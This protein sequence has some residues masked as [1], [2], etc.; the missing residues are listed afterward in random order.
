MKISSQST[1]H[2]FPQRSFLILVQPLCTHDLAATEQAPSKPQWSGPVFLGEVGLAPRRHLTV[3]WASPTKSM[4]E[5]G[6]R[7]Q[8]STPLH[9]TWWRSGSGQARAMEGEELGQ[10]GSSSGRNSGLLY[11]ASLAQN[12][13]AQASGTVTFSKTSLPQGRKFPP[14]VWDRPPSSR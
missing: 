14:L 13:N 10:P 12:G 8:G 7:Q 2:T 1:T 6:R 5:L 9:P 11:G 4:Q 3:L